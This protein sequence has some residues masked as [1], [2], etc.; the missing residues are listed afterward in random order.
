MRS[1]GRSITKCDFVKKDRG[2]WPYNPVE[3]ARR[4]TM[5]NRTKAHL[6]NQAGTLHARC[7]QAAG[8]SYFAQPAPGLDSVN[9]E[10]QARLK[11]A[12][13]LTESINNQCL[14]LLD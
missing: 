8:D 9:S 11:V 7:E 4:V 2:T 12:N 5:P 10:I 13:E 6:L 1:L 14:R 3:T